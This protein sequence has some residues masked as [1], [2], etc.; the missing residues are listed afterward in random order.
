[1]KR[2]RRGRALRRRYGHA[3]GPAFRSALLE[4]RSRGATRV[5]L[6]THPMVFRPAGARWQVAL[7]KPM[8]GGGY[9]LTE[10]E[11]T[12]VAGDRATEIDFAI[13]KAA[14]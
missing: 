8:T 1:M 13:R 4:A 9:Y 5:E 7:V 2:R 14:A 10:W 12:P 11:W 3:S 6:G